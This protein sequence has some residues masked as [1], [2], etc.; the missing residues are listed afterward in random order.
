MKEQ[1]IIG[2]LHTLGRLRIILLLAALSYGLVIFPYWV[3]F[4]PH[5]PQLILPFP[6]LVML[7]ALLVIS[8]SIIIVECARILFAKKTAS[9]KLKT[10][11]S[12]VCMLIAFISTFQVVF[13]FPTN[14]ML[15]YSQGLSLAAKGDYRGAID[16]LDIAIGF[17]P[18]N[19][20]A[21]LERGYAS[22]KVGKF[23]SALNDFDRALELKPLSSLAY[24]GRGYAYA[25]LGYRERAI[26]DFKKSK[27]LTRDPGL[28]R[29]L[30]SWIR[31]GE[32]QE[33]DQ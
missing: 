10:H 11:I 2:W 4:L 29:T 1:K 33:E 15:Y 27:M 30:D 19:V 9:W 13:V 31:E 8:A 16:C 26:D 22:T 6:W 24:A 28:S 20:D 18:R 7:E 32:Q 25:R 5:K 21:Y 17:N 3:R 12:L 23:K 14:S